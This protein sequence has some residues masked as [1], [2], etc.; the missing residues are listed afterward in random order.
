MQ[1][2]LRRLAAALAVVLAGGAL[3]ADG[4]ARTHEITPEDYFTLGYLS[5][6]RVSPDGRYAVYGE[7]RWE[8]KDERQNVDLW[9]VE[10]ANGEVRRLTFDKA[11]DGQPAFGADG[12]WIYF[13]SSRKRAG[14]EKPPYDGTRQ[15]WRVSPDGGEPRPVTRVEEGVVLF[16]LTSDGSALYYTVKSKET[17]DG[18]KELREAHESLEYGHGVTE[19][20]E[21]WRLDLR[22]WRARKLVDEKRVIQG[23]RVAPGQGRI[24]MITTPDEELIHVEGWSRVDVYDAES[25]SIEVVTADGWRADHASPFGWLNEVAWSADGDALAFSISF[26]GYPT[27]LY[28]AEWPEG[29]ARIRR[30]RRPEGGRRRGR[31][32][33]LARHLEGAVL[34]RAGEGACAGLSDP[35]GP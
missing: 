3:L 18:W 24:A 29:E 5:G 15:I 23:L 33:A 17:D 12:K 8:A 25:E 31:L 2:H 28:A 32:A 27:Q 14:E 4:P 19:F 30:L 22:D 1:I 7:A 10:L 13:A 11:R 34:R 21:L 35:G 6:V 26:D 20:S 16:D 9:L